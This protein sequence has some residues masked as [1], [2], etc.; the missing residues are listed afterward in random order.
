MKRSGFYLLILVVLL[1]TQACKDDPC[2]TTDCG[3]F[4]NCITM[5]KEAIC[6]CE[7]SFEKDD[8]GLCTIYGITHFTGNFTS[9]ETCI[10][11]LRNDST[12]EK[13]YELTISLASFSEIQLE[14][15]GG[16]SCTSDLLKVDATVTGNDF[17]LQSGAYCPNQANQTSYVVSGNG[18]I[19][20]AGITFSYSLSFSQFGTVTTDETC[21]VTLTAK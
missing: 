15:L 20:Q 11:H 9:T 18:Q 5:D 12:F 2:D 16:F 4:G 8:E 6:Q 21:S 10:N 19:D 14:G 3:P 1:S 7:D 17:Q 13:S